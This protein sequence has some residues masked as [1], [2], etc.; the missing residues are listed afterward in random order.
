MTFL[1]T[2]VCL[3]LS[4]KALGGQIFQVRSRVRAKSECPG[5][6]RRRCPR[7]FPGCFDEPAE[8]P[9]RL[10]FHSSSSQQRGV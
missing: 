3:C 2:P 4:T 8:R 5:F 9:S 6:E 1:K 10:P 7:G